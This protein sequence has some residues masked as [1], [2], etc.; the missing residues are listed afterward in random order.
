MSRRDKSKKR[1]NRRRRATGKGGTQPGKD[2]PA[3]RVRMCEAKIH[4]THGGQV[5]KHLV[6]LSDLA[7]SQRQ[8]VRGSL[9]VPD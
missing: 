4:N 2:S 5:I 7:R 9:A 8:S 6:P 1:R 3:F